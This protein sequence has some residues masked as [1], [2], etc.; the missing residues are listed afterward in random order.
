MEEIKGLTTKRK[1][2]TKIKEENEEK[3]RRNEGKRLKRKGNERNA[4]KSTRLN[5]WQE[6]KEESRR[7]KDKNEGKEN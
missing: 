2:E 5:I 1:G 6:K 4:M 7:E 3:Q